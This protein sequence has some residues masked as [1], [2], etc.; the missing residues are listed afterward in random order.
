MT[1]TDPKLIE[2]IARALWIADDKRPGIWDGTEGAQWTAYGEEQK[3]SYRAKTVRL[4]DLMLSGE[5][6]L[7]TAAAINEAVQKERAGNYKSFTDGMEAA[8]QICGSLAETTYDDADAFE[9]AIGCEAA[10]M[11][12][13]MAQRREQA[14]IEAHKES[15]HGDA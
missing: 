11:R 13:V 7:Y 14:A 10:I 3:P 9:A 4:L 12:V 2:R 1:T 8:A 5:V 6:P 15:Q